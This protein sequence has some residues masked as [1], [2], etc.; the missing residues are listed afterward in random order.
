MATLTFVVAFLSM[1]AVDLLIPP[2]R[3][4]TVNNWLFLAASSGYYTLVLYQAK[5]H[6]IFECAC[7]A[8]GYLVLMSV[9]VFAAQVLRHYTKFH[10]TVLIRRKVWAK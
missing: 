9:W 7:Y 2:T 4:V 10:D 1:L 5:P 3:N 8:A 6:S